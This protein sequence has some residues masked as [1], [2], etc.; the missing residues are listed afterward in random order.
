M[1]S[2]PHHRQIL[3]TGGGGAAELLPSHQPA[4]LQ[5]AAC[6]LQASTSVTPIDPVDGLH[7][8]FP[9]LLLLLTHWHHQM[10]LQDVVAL[11]VLHQYAGLGQFTVGAKDPFHQGACRLQQHGCVIAR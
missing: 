1:G 9:F 3:E 5:S 11:Q 10:G 7:Q 8:A 2:G 4:R 6:P